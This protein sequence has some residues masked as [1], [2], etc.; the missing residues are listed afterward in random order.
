MKSSKLFPFHK[1]RPLEP[2]RL[3][4]VYRTLYKTFGHQKWWPGQTPFEIIVGAILT[5]NTAWANVEKAIRNLKKAGSLTPRALHEISHRALAQRIKPSGYFNIKAARL[6]SFMEFL[7]SEYAGDLNKMFRE[8]GAVLREKLLSV[9][10]IGPETADSILLYA[11]D[12]LYFVIDAYTKRIFSRHRLQVAPDVRKLNRR[13][14]AMDYQDWQQI[15]TASLPS[16]I[17]LYNDYH[18]QIVILGKTYCR[19]AHPNCSACPLQKYL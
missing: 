1:S 7:F 9:K 17:G 11:G 16:D 10:G 3:Q 13:L 4:E 18:A 6:K 15:F 5:Q 14:S 12:K 2:D 19:K 8:E